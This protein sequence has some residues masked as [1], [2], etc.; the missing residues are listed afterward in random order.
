MKQ[1]VRCDNDGTLLVIVEDTTD[2]GQR[3]IVPPEAPLKTRNEPV[4]GKPGFKALWLTCPKCGKE[5][6]FG[7]MPVA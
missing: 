4:P 5:T 1:E 7:T 6:F 2:G 3:W